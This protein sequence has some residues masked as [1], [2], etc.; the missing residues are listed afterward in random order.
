MIIQPKIRGFICATAHPEGCLRAVRNQM[1][2]VL[3]QGELRGPR[4]VLVIGA[5]TG[6]G[7]ASRIVATFASHAKTIGVFFE[8]AADE[9]RTASP[10]WYNS[11]A[12]ESVAHDAGFYAKSING[13]AFSRDV[14]EQTA[15]LI[16]KDLQQVDL[17]I[18]SVASPRRT[19]PDSGITFSSTLKPIG[20]VFQGKTVDAFRG[21]IKDVK[22]EPANE[23]EIEDT[24][25]VMGG[26]DWAMWIDY[27]LER[28]LLAHGAQTIAYS[29]IGPELTH[30]I[31]KD[32]T[33]GQAKKDLKNTADQL[34]QRL[35]SI[36]G[37]ASVS[38]NKA[39]VTQAS[40]AIPVVPLYISILF[41]LMKEAGTHE[42]CVEQIYR[43]FKDYLYATYPLQRDRDGYIRIDDLEMDP[44]LQQQVAGL[45][46]QINSDNVNTLTDIEGYRSDFYELFGFNFSDVNYEQD[47]NPDVKITSITS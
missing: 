1:N 11:A 18:Y 44:K 2:Y 16:A 39:V 46:T 28:N 45:W 37:S 30:A 20:Q 26:E 8:R 43:L 27:L 13:D 12:F 15:D 21:E 10:G 7:L 38:V 25:A 23:K 34:N 41:K 22:I 40:A 31:Y 47:V 4:N 6:Y 32:G 35:Q 33:I 42:G 24:I 19:H 36:G 29:Y 14:K 5:S 17:I 3:E 9:K